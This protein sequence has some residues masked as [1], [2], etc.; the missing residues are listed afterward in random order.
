MHLN[1]SKNL[2]VGVCIS[3]PYKDEKEEPIFAHQEGNM[4]IIWEG[5]TPSQKT[6]WRDVDGIRTPCEHHFGFGFL[7]KEELWEHRK[8]YPRD[9]L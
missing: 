7:T 4:Q 3:A 9:G 1:D 6:A 2:Y 5:D 8:N